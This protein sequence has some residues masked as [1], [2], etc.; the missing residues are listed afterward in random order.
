MARVLGLPGRE[1][2]TL[3]QM[4]ALLAELG[5]GAEAI[6]AYGF[7]GHAD[8][9]NP[10][11]GGEA[12]A[13][14]GSGAEVVVAKSIG[15]LVTLLAERDHGLAPKACVFLATPMRRFHAQGWVPLL[16][17]HCAAIPTLFVQ[18]TDDFNGAFADL[19]EV[20]AR[21]R[22][23]R[24]VEIPGGDHLYEDIGRIAPPVRGWLASRGFASL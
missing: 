17:D 10:Q 20:V 14:G 11:L 12:A 19:A 8:H 13:A 6:Q 22:E 3:S 16:A 2:S 1:P 21:H 15:T 5:V 9:S 24:C 7:W 4:Q 18:Q 23:C